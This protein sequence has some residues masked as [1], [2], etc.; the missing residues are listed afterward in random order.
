[1]NLD[2]RLAGQTSSFSKLSIFFYNHSH[3]QKLIGIIVATRVFRRL[4]TDAVPQSVA[5][6]R[7]IPGT[8]P[9]ISPTRDADTVG[10]TSVNIVSRYATA[11]AQKHRLLDRTVLDSYSRQYQYPIALLE[12]EDPSVDGRSDHGNRGR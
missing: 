11:D 4:P 9:T 6:K 7:R 10:C 3:P 8:I 1:M 2:F 5:K 12:M